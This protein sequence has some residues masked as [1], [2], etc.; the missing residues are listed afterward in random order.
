VRRVR[1]SSIGGQANE[2]GSLHRAGIAA[3]LAAHGLAGAAVE[4]AGYVEGGP[5][6][7]SV[8][9]ESGDAVDDVR[10]RLSDGTLLLV[11]A[12]RE[13]G[14]DRQF[15]STMTQWAAQVP[16]LRDGDRVALAAG[17]VKGKVRALGPALARRRRLHAGAPSRA[18][19]EALKALLDVLQPMG[20]A[21]QV[22]ER[23]LDAAVVME[24]SAETPVDGGFREAARLLEGVI[25]RA[26]QAAEPCRRC[27]G[28]ST[29]RRRCG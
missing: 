29:G 26:G 11:Q 23:L 6:P 14:V 2:A 16:A 24:V 9:L 22:R 15:R 21:T 10:C 18:E 4:A 17:R 13:C 1:R 28:P 27:S 8:E 5:Y 25:V 12:K 20:L 3:Y 7:V 19:N